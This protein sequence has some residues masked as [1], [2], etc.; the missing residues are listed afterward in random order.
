MRRRGRCLN[1]RRPPSVLHATDGV[2]STLRNIFHYFVFM[3]CFKGQ[4]H[5]HHVFDVYRSTLNISKV[6]TFKVTNSFLANKM[7]PSLVEMLHCYSA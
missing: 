7:S 6:A 2:C 3:S 5:L 1:T 4:R